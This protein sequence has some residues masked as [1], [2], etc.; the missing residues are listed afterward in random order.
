MLFGMIHDVPVTYVTRG[1]AVY[2]QALPLRAF[3]STC[4]TERPNVER[5][6]N[7]DSC[8]PACDRCAGPFLCETVTAVAT[9]EY[10]P[11]RIF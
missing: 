6:E 2:W 1:P 11:C 10:F 5:V 3:C 8:A 7:N 9:V 4:A